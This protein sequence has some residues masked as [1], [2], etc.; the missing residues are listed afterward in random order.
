M[1]KT[2]VIIVLAGL[3][4][5]GQDVWAV[6]AQKPGHPEKTEQALQ[7]KHKEYRGAKKQNKHAFKEK[8]KEFK[9]AAEQERLAFLKSLKDTDASER[10]EAVAAHLAEQQQKHRAWHAAMHEKK[11]TALTARLDEKPGMTDE[12]KQKMITKYESKFQDKKARL[13][14][15]HQGHQEPITAIMMDASLNP[16][17]QQEA[18]RQYLR[19]QRQERMQEKR[20]QRKQHRGSK[21]G[22]KK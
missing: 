3:M 21:E 15:Q 17:A 4:T 16:E 22:W 7:G 10:A 20:Q 8:M 19:E 1:M 13:E 18:I 2:F 9:E 14:E 11:M 6:P 12:K 5:A